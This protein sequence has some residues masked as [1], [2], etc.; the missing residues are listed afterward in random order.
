MVYWI[1][2]NLKHNAFQKKK[3][4]K[5][6]IFQQWNGDIVPK[7]KGVGRTNGENSQET[8]IKIDRNTPAMHILHL[9]SSNE[10]PCAQKWTA[11]D[12]QHAERATKRSDIYSNSRMPNLRLW[13]MANRKATRLKR[14]EITLEN[15]LGDFDLAKPLINF[16]EAKH[17]LILPVTP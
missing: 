17:T 10:L 11:R 15:I 16:L 7:L 4:K 6:Q 1:R 14:K 2:C 8:M 12:V 13:K 9:I 5:K 3:K